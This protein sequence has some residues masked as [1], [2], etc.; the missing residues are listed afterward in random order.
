MAQKPDRRLACKVLQVRYWQHIVNESLKKNAFR[1]PVH[2]AFGHE[3]IAVA[4]SAMMDPQDRLVLSHRNIAYNLARAGALRPV[5]DEYRQLASGIGNGH[6]GSMNLANPAGGVIY[7]SSILGNNLPVACGIA[8]GHRMTGRQGIVT[9]LTGDGAME[10]GTFYET[11][12]IS[13]YQQLPLL[14]MI[15]NNKYAMSSTIEER[16]VPI[17]V[18]SMCQA[19]KTPYFYLTGNLVFDYAARLKDIRA[20]I[21]REAAPA[22]VEVDLSN[23]NRHAGP[24][25]GWP[26][27]PMK[28]DL[29]AGLIVQASVYDPVHVLKQTLP[30]D[31][32]ADIEKEALA[33]NWSG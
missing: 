26:T 9:V 13:K 15:E 17:A 7:T 1:V 20:A 28:I 24:T 4:V 29:Q 33:E 32:F 5:F 18:E 22:V 23:L 8:L 31:V 12:D 27:D 19:F 2:C 25:P 14:I 10:E 3:A 21:L 30:P 11:L 6:L 16:R